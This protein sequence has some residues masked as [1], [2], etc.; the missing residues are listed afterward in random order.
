MGT[1]PEYQRNQLASSVVG[2][3]DAPS[4]E[5]LA[6]KIREGSRG[7]S[8]FV[9]QKRK[10]EISGEQKLQKMS[11]DAES[12]QA[13]TTF[14]LHLEENTTAFLTEYEGRPID[15]YGQFTQM[16]NSIADAQLR[17][18]ENA[19]VRSQL[20]NAQQAAIR[21]RLKTL[22]PE[23]A[24]RLVQDTEVFLAE[25]INTVG[26]RAYRIH[27]PSDFDKLLV[28]LEGMLEPHKNA[29]GKN[30]A[31]TVS[32]ARASVAEQFLTGQIDRNPV[33]G[34]RLIESDYYDQFFDADQRQE[35]QRDA[36]SA[37]NGVQKRNEEKFL[38][39]Q[40]IDNR[41]HIGEYLDSKMTYGGAK[42]RI[43]QVR[44]EIEGERFEALG[45]GREINEVKLE[46]LHQE[47]RV[48]EIL[49]RR[50]L[51]SGIYPERTDP[52]KASKIIDAWKQLRKKDKN[53]FRA[54]ITLKNLVEFQNF[55]VDE[56][57]RGVISVK[58]YHS[59]NK[60]LIG[61]I[62]VKAD[63]TTGQGFMWMTDNTAED[64]GF[65]SLTKWYQENAVSDN[66]TKNRANVIFIKRVIRKEDAL[67]RP[68]TVDEGLEI[69]H[70]IQ[71]DSITGVKDITVFPTVSEGQMF[72]DQ[73]TKAIKTI[74]PD[75]TI[76][77][78][79]K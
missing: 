64:R 29:L 59:W 5:V 69:A 19:R 61:E 26:G 53:E 37:L 3:A 78:G 27:K 39:D 52:E 22:R 44:A 49:K 23:V 2:V 34:M 32:N 73:K 71:L 62:D 18:V 25:A 4:S 1:I 70:Q 40:I 42:E 65:E 57:D 72:Q 6:N 41:K 48:L 46:K 67:G 74:M 38:A 63:E 47:I 9:F 20:G 31:K 16:A 50:L 7:V 14:L 13:E 79:P 58:D 43:S 66:I 51:E 35:L 28:S 33:I 45:E 56:L 11:D 76:K 60:K 77:N 17:G 68:L 21:S 36:R 55:M 12:S 10:S 15:M 30:Y 8:N 75:K 24:K 54:D